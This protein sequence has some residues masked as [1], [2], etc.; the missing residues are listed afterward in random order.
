[1]NL[2]RLRL[3]AVLSLLQRAGYAVPDR[4]GVT[5]EAYIQALLD[6]LCELSSTDPLTGLLNRRSFLWTLEQEL[7][8]VARG[9]E[10]ALLLAV[11]IDHFKRVNDTHGHA[12]GDEVIRMVAQT[13]QR[14]VRP[15]DTV[16][17]IGGE[18]FCIACPNCSPSYAPVV[19]E[20]VRRAVAE[21]PVAWAPGQTLAVTVSCGGALATP[22][23]RG[24]VS[25]WLERAD[26]QLYRAKREGRNR[27]CLEAV[28]AADVS[29]EEKGLL[30]GWGPADSLMM[31]KRDHA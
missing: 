15:M 3:D 7:D 9:G 31:D 11:D 16:A 24:M 28:Q 22:W 29:A 13:L 4:E 1:M 20:R 14:C 18:E 12:V 17:R 25:D 8:R 23:I 30:L 21:T 26:R 6:G 19:A 5:Q 2:E 27:V 10:Y